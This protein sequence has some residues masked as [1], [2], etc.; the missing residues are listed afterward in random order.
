MSAMSSNVTEKTANIKVGGIP[1]EKLIIPTKSKIPA[2]EIK[3]N[4]PKDSQ[5]ESSVSRLNSL[6]RRA[7]IE[8]IVLMADS[9]WNLE[10]EERFER[11]IQDKDSE[12]GTDEA[13]YARIHKCPD[14]KVE[15]LDMLVD[16]IRRGDINIMDKDSMAIFNAS[17]F[18]MLKDGG[19]VIFNER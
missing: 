7:R 19:L 16:W 5:I 15:F 13:Q 4:Y 12:R 14:I 10:D 18:Y 6:E 9:T 17:G 8:K 2:C 11:D 1:I 3:R